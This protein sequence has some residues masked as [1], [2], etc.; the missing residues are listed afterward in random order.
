VGG[1][2]SII[3]ITSKDAFDKEMSGERKNLEKES[4]DPPIDVGLGGIL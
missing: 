2:I 3:L 4:T 1:K